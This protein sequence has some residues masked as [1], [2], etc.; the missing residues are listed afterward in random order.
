MQRWQYPIYNDLNILDGYQSPCHCVMSSVMCAYLLEN[1]RKILELPSC[2]VMTYRLV[3]VQY[4]N[5]K[6]VLTVP[7]CSVTTLSISWQKVIQLSSM[8][9]L[10][11]TVCFAQGTTICHSSLTDEVLW[12]AVKHS[13]LCCSSNNVTHSASRPANCNPIKIVHKGSSATGSVGQGIQRAC[14]IFLVLGQSLRVQQQH[15]RYQGSGLFYS[16]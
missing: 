14:W 15:L 3:P 9:S 5:I 11:C 8:S 16:A 13:C 10:L 7:W 6:D 4:C 1:H 2:K 12:S